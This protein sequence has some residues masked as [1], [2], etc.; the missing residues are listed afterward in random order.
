MGVS[1]Q[2]EL[3]VHH[4]SAHPLSCS[5]VAGLHSA[6]CYLAAQSLS[7]DSPDKSQAQEMQID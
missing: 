7:V 6:Q 2:Q 5:D 1:T 4:C 3:A